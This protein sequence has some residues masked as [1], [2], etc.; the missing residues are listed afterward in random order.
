[1]LEQ[2]GVEP[3]VPWLEQGQIEVQHLSSTPW[4]NGAVLSREALGLGGHFY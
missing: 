4:A 3:P 1:M 2:E